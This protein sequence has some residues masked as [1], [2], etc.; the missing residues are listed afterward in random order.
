MIGGQRGAQIG[1]ANLHRNH[2]G[3]FG[4]MDIVRDAPPDYQMQLVR[5]LASNT[6]KCAR[7]DQLKSGKGLG[8]RL[9]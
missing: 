1:L 7:A 6:A 5:M 8:N 9:R 3:L 2:T 4:Q